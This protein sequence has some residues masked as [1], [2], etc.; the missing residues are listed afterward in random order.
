MLQQNWNK[1]VKYE[2]IDLE[3]KAYF[4]ALKQLFSPGG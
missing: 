3:L 4:I 2:A 1:N